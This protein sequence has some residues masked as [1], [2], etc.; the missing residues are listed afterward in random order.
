MP[1]ADQPARILVLSSD[2]LSAK[3]YADLLEARG[4]DVEAVE[5]VGGW[6]DAL[7]RSRPALV[8]IDLDSPPHPSVE[9]ARTIRRDPR[10]RAIPMIAVTDRTERTSEVASVAEGCD[11]RIAKP[12]TLPD[13][14]VPIERQVARDA[15][16]ATP[17]LAVRGAERAGAEGLNGWMG[18]RPREPAV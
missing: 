17:L 13:F 9:A 7:V 18:P 5:S 11:D 12:I 8:L 10:F 4:Y 14:Y 16:S 1:P 3:L 2:E 15:A 6:A